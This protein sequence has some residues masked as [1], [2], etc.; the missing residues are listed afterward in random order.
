MLVPNRHGSSNS[1]RYGF[2]GQEKDDEL[3]GEGNSLNYTFR[4]HD[5]RVGRF[6]ATDPLEKD[7]PWNSPYAFSENSTIAY[8]ELEGGEKLVA[9]VKN[10][11]FPSI[12][13]TNGD[14]II[15]EAF[16]TSTL[17][18]SKDGFNSLSYGIAF[19][20]LG[21][22]Y[23]MG[24]NGKVY[25]GIPSKLVED[26][27]DGKKVHYYRSKNI[28]NKYFS[29]SKVDQVE[30][31]RGKGYKNIAKFISKHGNKAGDIVSIF[32]FMKSTVNSGEID[33]L[34]IL[35]AGIG[36]ALSTVSANPL[37]ATAT[38][39]TSLQ[40]DHIMAGIEEL[41]MGILDDF[42][43]TIPKGLGAAE[44]HLNTY[45]RYYKVLEQY[46]IVRVTPTVTAAYLSGQIPD[47]QGLMNTLSNSPIEDD[48][49]D[50][51]LLKHGKDKVE[52]IHIFIND[53]NANKKE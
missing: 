43:K 35:D 2:Q 12:S 52:V 33:A 30:A 9:I 18:H 16:L 45:K 31:F 49:T 25:Q 42:S 40:R 17:K 46:S 13:N 10:S 22:G 36:K 11:T 50:A 6:F 19:K 51:F 1:Y 23:L 38:I 48:L 5:P 41:N 15:I 20:K 27:I 24:S 4:M 44:G 53:S 14:E 29:T 32:S 26:L 37:I 7:Y 21:K 8:I 34:S 47:Y 39:I 3:K 28:G